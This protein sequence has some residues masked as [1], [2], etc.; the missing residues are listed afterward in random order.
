MI[1]INK[2]ELRKKCLEYRDNLSKEEQ[3]YFSNIVSDKLNH[4][5]CVIEARSIMCFVSFGSEISTHEL[6]KG[7]LKQGK[8]VS[9]PC[10]EKLPDGKRI[11]HAVL[12]NSFSDL[13][14]KGSYGILEPELNRSAIIEPCKME[15]V[16]VPGSVF[17][18][19]R[20]RIG[21]G[22][23]FYDRFL[24][25]TSA[26]CKKIGICYDFQ[27]QKDIPHEAHDVPLDLIITEKRIV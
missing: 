23:G 21:Y 6:I 3:L 19:R 11:M 22:G 12:I 25:K 1:K 9:V 18:I 24:I 26:H 17:D 10:L 7:W 4:L 8:K 27:V 2:S 15:V 16:I 5:Q 13:K 14:T 20:N